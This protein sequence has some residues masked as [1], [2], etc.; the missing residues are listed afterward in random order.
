MQSCALSSGHRKKKKKTPPPPPPTVPLALAQSPHPLTPGP[1]LNLFLPFWLPV[2][3]PP[4]PEGSFYTQS[5]PCPCPGHS[6]SVVSISPGT[7]SQPFGLIFEDLRNLTLINQLALAPTTSTG[8]LSLLP[9]GSLKSQQLPSFPALAHAV[10]SAWRISSYHSLNIALG[11][12]STAASQQCDSRQVT[13]PLW[14]SVGHR[15][16]LL[17]M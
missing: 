11:S 10:P 13:W 12:A 2:W 15:L 16:H 4:D 9:H 7:G 1:L 5:W 17:D 14:A 8:M 6:P 3:L